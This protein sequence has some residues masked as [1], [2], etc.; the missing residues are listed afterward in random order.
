MIALTEA[1]SCSA[2]GLYSACNEAKPTPASK[3][4]AYPKTCV[5]ELSR[6]LF[7]EPKLT[8]TRR[9]ITTPRIIVIAC[10]RT[11]VKMLYALFCAFEIPIIYTK[12]RSSGTFDN[13]HDARKET[14]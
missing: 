6:P 1:S 2:T 11:L 14:A 10:P 4:L 13:I 9:G 3:R 5:I 7:S 12:L 8:S